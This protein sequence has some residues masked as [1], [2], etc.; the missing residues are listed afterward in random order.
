MARVIFDSFEPSIACFDSPTVVPS[1]KKNDC[2]ITAVFHAEGASDYDAKS[3]PTAY[4]RRSG[5]NQF[6]LYS[7]PDVATSIGLLRGLGF[8]D[9]DPSIQSKLYYSIGLSNSLKTVYDSYVNSQHTPIVPFEDLVSK[10]KNFLI[11]GSIDSS[12]PITKKNTAI[13]LERILNASPVALDFI[14]KLSKSFIDPQVNQSRVLPEMM[15]KI[16][17]ISVLTRLSIDL[18]SSLA[19]LKNISPELHSRTEKWIKQ[20][21]I[22]LGTGTGDPQNLFEE[23]DKLCN[24]YGEQK[25]IPSEYQNISGLFKNKLAALHQIGTV[26]QSPDVQRRWAQS[27]TQL[28]GEE[29]RFHLT[30]ASQ[31]GS[32][33]TEVEKELR[34]AK[35]SKSWLENKDRV[36]EITD[37]IFLSAKPFI[38][39]SQE[40]LFTLDPLAIE[41]RVKQMV[42]GHGIQEREYMIGTLAVLRFLKVQGWMGVVRDDGKIDSK[43]KF[44]ITAE[45]GKTL[46][47]YEQKLVRKISSSVT[48][49]NIVLP[50]VEASICLIGGILA[51]TG[52]GIQNRNLTLT[53][54]TVT[55]FGCSALAVHFIP[56]RNPYL[57]DSLT[58]LLGGGL[59]FTAAWFATLGMGNSMMPLPG[60][61]R[62][63]VS[64]FGP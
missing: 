38:G 49:T 12:D 42:A 17:W 48:K 20:M 11:T 43:I 36:L 58:A 55:G 35:L 44:R 1:K 39:S 10:Y 56:N 8:Q 7:P 2:E 29:I 37:A 34:E 9:N 25:N 45:A 60:D 32:L 33:Q 13:L 50:I 63:P 15:P 64:G 26:S 59:G 16:E 3:P 61:G 46:E 21:I 62:N 53:G 14:D 19:A 22:Y 30:N 23:L 4:F 40:L 57:T 52:G 41:S 24:I 27:V 47:E 6:Y 51:G 31:S 5:S 28:M 54:S 18:T